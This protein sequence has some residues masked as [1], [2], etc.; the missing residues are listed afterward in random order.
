MGFGGEV[1]F[2]V[3]LGLVLL[4][5][6]Q[7][8]VMLKHAARVRAEFQ[9]ASR[10]IKSQLTSELEGSNP[11]HENDSSNEMAEDQ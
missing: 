10:N 1:L 7:L 3:A 9:E 6:K 5:P 11:E 8:H 2:M 4:G